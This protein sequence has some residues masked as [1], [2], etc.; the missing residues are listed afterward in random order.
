MHDSTLGPN[1]TSWRTF[2]VALHEEEA[3][4]ISSILADENRAD[5]VFRANFRIEGIRMPSEFLLLQRRCSRLGK[6]GADLVEVVVQ[7]IAD[8]LA[9]G[10]GERSS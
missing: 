5:G 6:D 9:T 7:Q 10:F 2:E 4:T 3:W 8:I 1:V